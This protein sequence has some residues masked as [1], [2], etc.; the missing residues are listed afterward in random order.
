MKPI[1]TV[2]LVVVTITWGVNFV[3]IKIGIDSFPPILFSALRFLLASVP[4][5]FFV[6]K[7]DVPWSLILGIGVMLC[8]VKF[9]LLFVAIDVGLPPGLSSIVLQSQAFFTIVLAVV[10]FDEPIRQVQI[11]GMA[12][13]AAGLLLVALTVAEPSTGMGLTLTL[14]AGIAWAC[15]NL[16]MKRAGGANMFA[17]IIWA[18]L[19]APAPLLMLSLIVEGWDR[20]VAALMNIDLAGI[21]ALLFVAYAATVFGF[22]VWGAM[23]KRYGAAKVAPFSLIVPVAG[24]SSSVLVLGEDFGQLRLIAALLIVTGLILITVRPRRLTQLLPARLTLLIGRAQGG[25][26][27]NGR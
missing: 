27:P 16:M 22:S 1:H 4:L 8:V 15:S 3:V 21:G 11:A 20:D 14:G 24:M 12:S 10:I 19:V 6:R 2:L 17:V 7:P 5:C 9:S 25:H 23:I 26:P 13:A 18:S